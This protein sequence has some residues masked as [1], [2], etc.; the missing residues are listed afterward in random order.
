[1]YSLFPGISHY[2]GDRSNN[3]EILTFIPYLGGNKLFY[4]IK[5]IICI[6]ILIHYITY[7][8]VTFNQI[9]KVVS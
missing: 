5:S 7:H 4:R 9:Y 8:R 2:Y 3:V 6:H 1:M